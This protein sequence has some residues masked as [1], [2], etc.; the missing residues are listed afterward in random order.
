ME[1]NIGR[2]AFMFG[3]IAVNKAEL[4]FKEY[5]VYRSFYCGL[6][7]SLKERGGNLSR[8]T[9]SYDMTFCTCCLQ[10]FMSRRQSA[11]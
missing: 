3:Y 8:L 6:C 9:L 1:E 11:F 7:K 5:D 4:K 10:G 2:G